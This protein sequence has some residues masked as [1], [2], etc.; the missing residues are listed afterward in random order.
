M[1]FFEALDITEAPSWALSYSSAMAKVLLLES[2]SP[3]AWAP[4]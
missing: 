3:L 1:L 2:C 4:E